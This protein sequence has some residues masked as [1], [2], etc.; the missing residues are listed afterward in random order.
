[1]TTV[2]PPSSAYPSSVLTIKSRSRRARRRDTVVRTRVLTGGA[3]RSVMGPGFAQQVLDGDPAP[4]LAQTRAG[5]RLKN[6]TERWV[7]R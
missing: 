1:M 3:R 6:V 5:Q 2:T 4:V 7:A